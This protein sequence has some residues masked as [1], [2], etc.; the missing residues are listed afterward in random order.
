MKTQFEHAYVLDIM[1]EDRPGIIA[2]VS[3]VLKRLG[4][5]IDKC[6]Q[7]V[8]E[9][10]F[11]LILVVSLP[12]P[13]EP[14]DL[15]REVRGKE[16]EGLQVLVRPFDES[17]AARPAPAAEP[18]VITAFGRDKPGIIAHLS[19]CLAGKDINITDLY[20][21]RTND[22]FVMVSQVAIPSRLDLAMLQAD[23]EAIAAQ[24]GFTVRLQHENIFVATN[25][26]RLTRTGKQG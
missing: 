16:A 6:S 2:R 20:W 7:T 23:L 15:A 19:Q 22:D 25:Q 26:L 18:F 5:N 11:T 8:L 3:G 12:K 1:A 9:G 13:V 24:E 4:G 10:Y 21:N 14:E 17:V